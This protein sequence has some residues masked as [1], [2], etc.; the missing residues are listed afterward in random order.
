MTYWQST[1]GERHRRN[2]RRLQAVLAQVEQE[3]ERKGKRGARTGPAFREAMREAVTGRDGWPRPLARLALDL[4]FTTARKQPPNLQNLAKH[5]LDQLS[6]THDKGEA[7]HL[8]ADDRQVQLLHVGA[9][10]GWDLDAPRFQPGIFVAARTA[11]DAVAD[12][13]AAARLPE[14]DDGYD[15]DDIRLNELREE[16]QSAER[17][18]NASEPALR[19]AAP[20]IRAMA[21]R[22]AQDVLLRANDRWLEHIFWGA[23]RRLVLGR[24]RRDPRVPPHLA[25]Q[26]EAAEAANDERARQ[27][28][29]GQDANSIVLPSLPG[30]PGHGD[31]FRSAVRGAVRGYVDRNRLLFPLLVPTR[32]SLF[33]VQPEQPRDL[34][35]ILLDV[36][37]IVDEIMKPPQEPWLMSAVEAADDETGPM[38][39]WKRR[40]LRRLRSV[41][42]Q[43]VW[44]CQVV[45]LARNDTDPPEGVLAAILG[46]GENMRSLWE[47]AANHLDK[48]H[49]R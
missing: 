27:V 46:H 12:M 31:R 22:S 20:Q 32:L 45:E 28:V 9:D 36:L 11:S 18:Q 23:A 5:Y 39:E 29:L 37:P 43:G 17:L 16:L 44:S 47:E 49:E 26:L 21:L 42:E 1:D 19:R 15:I 8:Y 4:H 30:V 3:P 25:E 14:P 48:E 41:I 13:A 34:D 6:A 10:H 40:R 24:G 33:V 38:A 2:H 7:G 35:N